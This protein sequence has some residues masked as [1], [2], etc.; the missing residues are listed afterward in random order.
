MNAAVAL[1]SWQAMGKPGSP[2]HAKSL[3]QPL[4]PLQWDLVRRLEQRFAMVCRPGEVLTLPGG[5]AKSLFEKVQAVSTAAYGDDVGD[6][7]PLT[8]TPDNMSLPT[9]G[10][11]IMLEAPVVP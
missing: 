6:A 8:L 9:H 1:L 4:S 3:A 10:A 5:G 11:R 2:D 7:A